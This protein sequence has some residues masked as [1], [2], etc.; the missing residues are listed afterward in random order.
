M[1]LGAVALRREWG[2]SHTEQGK[3][4]ETESEGVPI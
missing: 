3:K 2:S 1:I 4:L